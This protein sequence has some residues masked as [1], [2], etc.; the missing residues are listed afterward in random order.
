LL[1]LTWRL[2]AGRRGSGRPGPPVTDPAFLDTLT[3]SPTVGAA[4]G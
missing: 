2:V 3:L 1:I 4:I